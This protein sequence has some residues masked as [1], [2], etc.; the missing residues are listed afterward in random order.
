MENKKNIMWSSYYTWIHNV[1][2]NVCNADGQPIEGNIF[3]CAKHEPNVFRVNIPTEGAYYLEISHGSTPTV[4][5]E[6][7]FTMGNPNC[8]SGTY[9][10]SYGTQTLGPENPTFEVKEERL[11]KDNSLPNYAIVYQAV[12]EGAPTTATSSRKIRN[13]SNPSWITAQDYTWKCNLVINDTNAL[14]QTWQIQYNAGRSTKSI[15]PTLRMYYV[16]P[17][18]PIEELYN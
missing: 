13:E 18:Y 12:L 1:T 2:I 5:K 9:S 7:F 16:Y 8:D 6:Y 11:K 15:V 17:L 10:A 4:S 3:S 14:K